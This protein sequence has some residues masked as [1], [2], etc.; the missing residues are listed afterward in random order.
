MQQYTIYADTTL[1]YIFDAF[2]TSPAGCAI[3]YAHALMT[4]D[5]GVIFT[6]ATR[7]FDF[8]TTD[9]SLASATA[10]FYQ[11]YIVRVT[12]SSS[13]VNKS[14]VFTIRVINPCQLVAVTFTSSISSPQ[15]ITEGDP[16]STITIPTYSLDPIFT[17]CWDVVYSVTETTSFSPDF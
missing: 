14:D 1:T 9:L 17:E 13:G 8:S 11:D 16:A 5:P 2:V 10:P 4:A 6:E 7:Q 12:A 3:S 15:V